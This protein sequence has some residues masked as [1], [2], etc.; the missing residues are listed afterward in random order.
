MITLLTQYSATY[1]LIYNFKSG[2]SLGLSAEGI[3]GRVLLIVTGVISI[4]IWVAIF[5]AAAC[6]QFG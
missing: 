1:Y 5:T 6:R 3:T 4:L 2:D